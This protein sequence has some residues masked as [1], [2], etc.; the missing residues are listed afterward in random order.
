MPLAWSSPYSWHSAQGSQKKW[1]IQSGA[2]DSV[3]PNLPLNFLDYSCNQKAQKSSPACLPELA[4]AFGI[5]SAALAPPLQP[6]LLVLAGKSGLVVGMSLAHLAHFDTLGWV[7]G[8]DEESAVQLVES[9]RLVVVA[10][11]EIVIVGLGNRGHFVGLVGVRTP[12]GFVVGQ[13]GMKKGQLGYVP[14][15]SLLDLL[16]S[17]GTNSKRSL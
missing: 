5:D 12:F 16:G 1:V 7:V 8:F 17:C 14:L 10:A 9:D 4:L 6:Q 11:A 2:G 15:I 3:R 13:F